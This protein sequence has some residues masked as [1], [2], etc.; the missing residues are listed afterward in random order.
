MQAPKNN[1]AV[2]VVPGA[3]GLVVNSS[4]PIVPHNPTFKDLALPWAARGFKTIPVARGAKR[5]VWYNWP[6]LATNTPEGV[7]ALHLRAETDSRFTSGWNCGLVADPAFQCQLDCDAPGLVEQIE[8]ETGHKIP[9]TLT[10]L[11]ANKRLPHF[12]F[13]HTERTRGMK[14]KSAKGFDFWTWHQQ[15]LAPGSIDAKTGRRYELAK[16]VPMVPIPD[17]L[18]DWIEKQHRDYSAASGNANAGALGQLKAAYMRNLDPEDLYTIEGLEIDSCQHP[19]LHS[20]ACVLHNG[21]RTE[22]DLVE[23]LEKVWDTYCSRNRQDDELER[24]ARNVLEKDP[25][26]LTKATVTFGTSRKH[27]FSHAELLA[28][29]SAEPEPQ[30]IE[31]FL[32]VRSQAIAV[33]ESTIGKTPMFLQMGLCVANGVD[34]LGMPVKQG[35]VM[36]LDYENEDTPLADMLGSLSG[37]LGTPCPVDAGQLQIVTS[38]GSQKEALAEVEEFKPAL[39][40]VDSLRGFDPLAEKA[41]DHAALLFSRLKQIDAAWVIIHHPRKEATDSKTPQIPLYDS[42]RVVDWLQA[43]SGSR[44]LINQSSTRIAIDAPGPAIPGEL[45]M[46]WNLKGIGDKGPVYISREVDGQGDPAGYQKITGADLLKDDHQK[47]LRNV[48]MSRK[49][50]PPM[51][52]R[53]VQAALPDTK[54]KHITRFL[55]AAIEVGVATVEGKPRSRNRT[56]VF[57]PGVAI[58][59]S[60]SV[61]I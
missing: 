38:P 51:H 1:A 9:E 59:G 14:N 25:C 29:V 58:S 40:I 34:F 41:P 39:V 12:Y 46:R 24:I 3:S 60:F 54:P 52:F 4:I 21:E 22:E 42:P 50:T 26:R 8:R 43:A 20:L 31:G 19:T 23:I 30:I 16:D 15:T 33:G 57:K 27:R 49:V 55:D 17:W 53:D 35:R 28:R 47:L 61:G 13:L 56:Y 5:P 18:V 32:G 48:L 45:L 11:S 6:E 10:V 44:A 37:F 36:I 7:E 2:P